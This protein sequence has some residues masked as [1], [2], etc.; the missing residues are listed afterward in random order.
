MKTVDQ[1]LTSKKLLLRLFLGMHL[2]GGMV[3]HLL[4]GV[5]ELPLARV[6]EEPLLSQADRLL[7]SSVDTCAQPS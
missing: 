4:P 6:V 3:E 7:G 1:I 5:V 2:D